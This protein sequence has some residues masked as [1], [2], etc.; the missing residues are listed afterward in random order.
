[1]APDLVNR[2]HQ[3]LT[4][5]TNAFRTSNMPRQIN[6]AATIRRMMVERAEAAE[7]IEELQAKLNGPQA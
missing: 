1:M 4:V 6:A 7:A 3:E 5:D 2:L